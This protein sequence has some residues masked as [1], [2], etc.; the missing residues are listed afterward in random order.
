MYTHTHTH[1]YIGYEA[2]SGFTTL[3]Y[4]SF[5][6][7]C[8]GPAAAGIPMHSVLY[9]YHETYLGEDPT[10]FQRPYLDFLDTT[11]YDIMN[12][13]VHGEIRRSWRTV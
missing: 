4:G 2:P 11:N 12:R 5:G 6:E 8:Q 7:G 10:F 1:T 9:P 3:W 13:M